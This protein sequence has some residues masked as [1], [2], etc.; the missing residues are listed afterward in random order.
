M[1][2]KH[3][4]LKWHKIIEVRKEQIREGRLQ[5]YRIFLRVC[6]YLSL[7][8]SAIWLADEEGP[9]SADS[10]SLKLSQWL[11]QLNSVEILKW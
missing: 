3:L 1:I 10:F 6:S 4:D 2:L 9:E 5:L 8:I 11:S 7:K